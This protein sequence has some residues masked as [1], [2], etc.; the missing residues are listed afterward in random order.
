M[1]FYGHTH[2]QYY[3]VTNSITNPD[4]HIHVS[5][6]GPSVTTSN[7]K[8]PAYGYMEMDSEFLVPLNYEMY[9]MN[10]TE[11]NINDKP[12]WSS[13]YINYVKDYNLTDY[14]SP[15]EMHA[16]AERVGNDTTL[17]QLFNWDMPRKKGNL[18]QYKTTAKAAKELGCM[19]A[20]SETFEA[21]ACNGVS[22]TD[23]KKDPS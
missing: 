6:I 19:L 10:I 9:A 2:D 18:D 11:A 13:N 8:N 1:Q 4:K 20:T 17:A 16:L 21:N 3:S 14:V 7:D 15:N 12:D 5:Q 22:D 23:W